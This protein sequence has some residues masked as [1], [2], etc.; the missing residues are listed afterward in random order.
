MSPKALDSAADGP[1]HALSLPPEAPHRGAARRRP[2]PLLVRRQQ[3]LVSRVRGP[4]GGRRAPSLNATTTEKQIFTKRETEGARNTGR[5]KI[6]LGLGLLVSSSVEN[7]GNARWLAGQSEA[8][9]RVRVPTFA[10]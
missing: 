2:L 4:S 3:L 1:R 5:K 9:H 7:A 8:E 10:P 6:G